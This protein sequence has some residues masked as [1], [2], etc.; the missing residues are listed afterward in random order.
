M[1]KKLGEVIGHFHKLSS[2]IEPVASNAFQPL[3]KTSHLCVFSKHGTQRGQSDMTAKLSDF[4][5]RDKNRIRELSNT[6]IFF[7]LLVVFAVWESWT[8]LPEECFLFFWD[9]IFR[10]DLSKT[11]S[12]LHF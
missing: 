7:L 8:S 3:R 12:L 10:Q 2:L 4:G 5:N 9:K 6:F 11:L 1:P